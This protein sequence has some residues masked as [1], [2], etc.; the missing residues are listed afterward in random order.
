LVAGSAI[1]HDL[2]DVLG[3]NLTTPYQEGK[4]QLTWG[5]GFNVLAL[6]AHVLVVVVL[7]SSSSSSPSSFEA[8]EG[9]GGEG[10]RISGE[11]AS[12]PAPPAA[13][14]GGG[15]GLKEPLL[16]LEEGEQDKGRDV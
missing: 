6:M 9:M 11:S 14:K 7:V 15:G 3:R 16:T 4:L 2:R 13:S 1:F 12:P 10:E 5:F 8:G